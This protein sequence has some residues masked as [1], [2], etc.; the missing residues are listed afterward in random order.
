MWSTEGRILSVFDAFMSTGVWQIPQSV[1]SRVAIWLTDMP[2]LRRSSRH[3][4]HVFT[5]A[6]RRDPSARI[7]G[8]SQPQMTHALLSGTS[9]PCRR[10]SWAQVAEQNRRNCAY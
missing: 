2:C 8:I 5:S 4:L 10:Q 3:R 7:K 6:R 9:P 1:P